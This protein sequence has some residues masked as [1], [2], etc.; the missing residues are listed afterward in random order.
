MRHAFMV[1][2]ADGLA[3]RGIAT[4]RHHSYPALRPGVPLTAGGKSFGGRMTSRAQSLE[5]LTG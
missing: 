4:L 3:T 1:K 5:P 2:V